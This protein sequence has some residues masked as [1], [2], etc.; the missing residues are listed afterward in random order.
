MSETRSQLLRFC[1]IGM[2]NGAITYISLFVFNRI[3]GLSLHM[4]NFIGYL[5]VLAHSFIWSKLWIF[6]SRGSNIMRE[7]AI[8]TI[9]FLVAYTM[10]FV[11]FYSLTKAIGVNEYWANLVSL[12]VFGA[13]NFLINRNYTF[14]HNS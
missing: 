5:L 12:I 2:L 8:F 3:L 9:T 7:F 6:K 4:S 1:L 11:T 10:Q 13:S 14:R